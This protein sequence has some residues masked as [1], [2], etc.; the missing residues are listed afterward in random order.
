[1]FQRS[2]P[3][4]NLPD[5]LL[6]VMNNYQEE[7]KKLLQTAVKCLQRGFIIKNV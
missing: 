4:K 1:M 5:N 6:D 2:L 3:R 7:I